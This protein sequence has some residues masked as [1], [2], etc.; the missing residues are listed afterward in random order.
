MQKLIPISKK[1]K[2]D[3]RG[4]SS[5]KIAALIG[6]LVFVVLVGALAPTFFSDINETGGPAWVNTVLPIV[7][8]AGL[9]MA[10]WRI[11]K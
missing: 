5:G 1:P 2:M 7:V 11:F 8:G 4:I 3:K 9:V 10:V 6:A